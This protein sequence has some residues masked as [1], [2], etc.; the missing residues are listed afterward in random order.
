[1]NII[2]QAKEVPTTKGGSFWAGKTRKPSPEMV[3]MMLN[4]ENIVKGPKKQLAGQLT[5]FISK[6]GMAGIKFMAKLPK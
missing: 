4:W 5:S 2:H 1:M 3:K 6:Y